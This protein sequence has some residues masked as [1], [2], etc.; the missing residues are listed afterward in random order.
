MLG[1]LLVVLVS[2]VLVSL[3]RSL[4]RLLLSVVL[5]WLKNTA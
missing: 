1:Q 2:A 5:K 3:L 4:H